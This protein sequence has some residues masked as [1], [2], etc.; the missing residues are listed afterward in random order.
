MNLREALLP[1]FHT[2][3]ATQV[4]FKKKKEGDIKEQVKKGV[5]KPSYSHATKYASRKS[6]SS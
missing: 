2:P 1:N 3:Y 6:F 5:H 4:E